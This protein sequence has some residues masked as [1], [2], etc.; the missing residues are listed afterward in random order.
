LAPLTRSRPRALNGRR[1]IP[2]GI[3]VVALALLSPV[4]ASA[5]ILSPTTI[6]G[7]STDGLSLG[8]VAMAADGTGGLVYTK[9]VGGVQH[10]F[11]SRYDG[12]QWSSPMQV[13]AEMPL[14]A[15]QARIAAGNNGRLLVVWV[16]PVATLAKGGVRYGLYS[17]TLGSGAKEFG[18]ALLVDANVGEGVDVDPSVAGTTPGNAIVAYRVITD[19]FRKSSGEIESHVQL[20]EG[21]VMAEIRA[22]RLEG[23][24][25]SKLPALNR[26]PAA[27]M[28]A[29]T[30]ANAPQVAIGATGRA[31][32]AWQ[33][34]DLTGAAR[35][36][37]R[38][39]TG[40]TPGPVFLASPETWNGKAITEDAT[41]FSLSVSALD[42]AR[43]AA[44]VE[45]GPG[46]PLGGSRVFLTTLG[47]STTAAGA[48]PT[49]PEP[50]DGPGA[51][52]PGPIGPPAV[53]ASIG[54]GIEGSMRL[55]FAAG[56]TVRSVGTDEHGK[57]LEPES[58]PG[59]PPEPETPT[60]A[61]VDPEGGTVVAYEAIGEGGVPAVA[62]NQT[63]GV[64]GSQSGVLYGPIGGPVSQLVGAGSGVGDA[65]FAFRQGEAGEFALVADR[66][67]AAPGNF[68][69]H[70]PEHWVPP[71]RA[72]IT[73]A[74][75]PSA[76]G[77]LHFGLLLNGRLVKS[78]LQV[79]RYTPPPSKLPSGVGKVQV[80]ATDPF[81]EEVLSKP[82]KL[83]VDSQP[84]RLQVRVQ[85]RLDSVRVQLLD[86]QSGLR[87][88]ATRIAFGDGTRKRSGAKFTHRY[89][90]PG[91]YRIRL[92]AEDKV[93]NALVQGLRVTVR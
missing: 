63:F 50:A 6:D 8:G 51:P 89:P 13:D 86:A 56:A 7:P 81:G 39:I 30:E 58:V 80:V 77:E 60:V 5:L 49:G 33:E 36:L 41:A 12:S 20:R 18:S 82:A 16:T 29:P 57:M 3:L 72:T 9:T 37:M 22:A 83:R 78:G 45:A 53:S 14:A 71:G 75:P 68:S 54:K 73:W 23:G 1:L 28:R 31:V 15:S 59:P 24:R 76:A 67:A 66:V 47:A 42:Q 55:A 19:A 34:P 88:G 62:V 35:I 61:T 93:G 4:P 25:W 43:V 21:D 74:A 26:N 87:R 40:T 46:S 48:K 10:V 17:A 2:T 79:H 38:R 52:L 85:R 70:V 11:A 65:L 32:V 90:G 91:T 44:V 92:R 27:S 64:G 84:P 69:L